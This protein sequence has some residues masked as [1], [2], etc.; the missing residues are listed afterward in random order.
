MN[1]NN[2]YT[3]ILN[4]EGLV[5][6]KKSF[7]QKITELTRTPGIKITIDLRE[8]N[9]ISQSLIRNLETGMSLAAENN[10][11]VL[12]GKRQKIIAALEDFERGIS[13]QFKILDSS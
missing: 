9:K 6:G 5:P 12:W 3:I 11:V 8:V 4:S 10:E 2:P 13:N 7:F 1:I